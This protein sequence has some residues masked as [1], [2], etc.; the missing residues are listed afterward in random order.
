[1]SEKRKDNPNKGHQRLQYNHK[2]PGR[3]QASLSNGIQRRRIL[4][5]KIPICKENKENQVENTPIYY[6]TYYTICL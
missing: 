2:R 5:V 6:T 3:C 4:R 1:M